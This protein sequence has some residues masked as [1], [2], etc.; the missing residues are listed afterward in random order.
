M[1]IACPMTD[2]ELDA[3]KNL[4]TEWSQVDA[5]GFD[6]YVA[7][8][9]ITDHI[10]GPRFIRIRVNQTFLETVRRRMQFCCTEGLHET[11]ERRLPESWDG[12]S[13]ERSVGV[14]RFQVNKTEFWFKA[15]TDGVSSTESNPIFISSLT[16]L[17]TGVP[18]KADDDDLFH[19]YGGC[20]FYAEDDFE[21]LLENV[22][23]QHPEVAARQVVIEMEAKIRSTGVVV[24]QV[25]SGD[26]LAVTKRKRMKI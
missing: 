2:A 4:A 8:K 14:W 9:D 24:T 13:D 23:D 17:V 1:T 12:F 20:V 10:T 26:P 22:L 5:N 7:N 18:W 16:D 15:C 19:L 21:D 3:R 11:V 6:L 25:D